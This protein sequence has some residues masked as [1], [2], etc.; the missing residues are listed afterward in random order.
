M[1][2]DQGM[3]KLFSHQIQLTEKVLDLRLQRQNIVT[4]TIAN[5]NTPGYKARRLEF[6]EKLQDA[7][8]QNSLGKMTRTQGAHLPS[9]FSA[10]GFKGEAFDNFTAREVYGQDH[11]NLETEITNSA[12]N[13]MMYNALTQVIKKNFDGMSRVI[14]EGS[15]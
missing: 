11:V 12:K 3:S 15:K 8:N 14:S 5:V 6:E 13:T 4:G 2:E 7:L 10:A 9:T 1:Q